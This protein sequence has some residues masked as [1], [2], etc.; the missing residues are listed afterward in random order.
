VAGSGVLSV[1]APTHGVRDCAVV[2]EVVRTGQRAVVVRMGIRADN[3]V[4]EMVE[5]LRERVQR[6]YAWSPGISR[7]A[8]G[9]ASGG[10]TVAYLGPAGTFSEDAARQSTIAVGVRAAE[11]LAL[12]DFAEVLGAVGRSTL[13]VLPLTSSS[14]GLV[15]RSVLALLE[16]AGP[17]VAG[18]VADVAVRFDAYVAAGTRLDELRGAAVHSHPQ[19]LAQCSGFIRRWRLTPVPTS[20]TYEAVAK[21]ASGELSG[22]ALAGSGRA[23]VEPRLRVAEREIDDLSGS[24]TRFLIVGDPDSFGAFVGGS[25]PTLR[26][27]VIG[28]GPPPGGGAEGVPSY[29]EVLRDAAG[30]WLCVSS[31]EPVAGPGSR[32][33]GRVPWSPRTPVVRVS[34]EG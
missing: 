32:R 28:E 8:L 2:S 29:D 10:F 33:L 13:A 1:V 26:S 25:D 5:L 22:V 16:H 15:S 11:F 20:S 9:G 4:E 19:A 30:R 14:S 24:V 6:A 27:I 17:L 18:G 23:A 12:A 7:P 31:G 21:L 3:D 34:A